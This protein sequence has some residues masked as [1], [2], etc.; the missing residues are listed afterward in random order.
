MI[1]ELSNPTARAGTAGR[2]AE[3][4]GRRGRP[5]QP[6][7]ADA[8]RLPAAAGLGRQHRSRLQ[9]SGAPGRRQRTARGQGPGVDPGA[10]AVQAGRR[11]TG[12]ART[13]SPTKQLASHAESTQ[14]RLAVQ[15][16]EVDQVRAIVQLK[17]RQVDELHVRAGIAGVLQLVP[18]DVGQQVAPGT[19]LA[20]VADPSRLKAELKIAE[21]QAKDVQIG[22]SASIDTRNGLVDG[23]RG[24]DR[25]V[26]A[27]RHRDRRCRD[28]RPAPQGRQAGFE[29]RRQ[30][31]A[32][33]FERRAVRR[34][35]G[36]RAGTE[37][38]RAVQAAARTAPRR[39]PRSSLAGAR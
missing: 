39:A 37:R 8:E 33:A 9:E 3:V 30:D 17:Q 24:A 23:T 26:G 16:A 6:A 18:V 38:C 14:A 4:E 22:Q 21:T 28:G 10:E 7:R 27:E 5:R 31:R 13:R 34:P 32:G 12:R 29:R 2:R 1:L 19:N 15:Q 20:R 25:S 11:A 36:V 35:A